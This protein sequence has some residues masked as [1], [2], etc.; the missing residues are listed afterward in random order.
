MVILDSLESTLFVATGASASLGFSEEVP[1]PLVVVADTF[2]RVV[3]FAG[4]YSIGTGERLIKITRR[5]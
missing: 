2:G 3:H 5:L 1:S 4:G